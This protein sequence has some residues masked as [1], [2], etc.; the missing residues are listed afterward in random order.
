MANH[1]SSVSNHTVDSNS[2]NHLWEWECSSNSS[3]DSQ[4]S[5]DSQVMVSLW[6]A[7]EAC[8]QV[9]EANR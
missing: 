8:S 5:E 1:S 4:V 3:A 7:W 2:V 6:A 9:S